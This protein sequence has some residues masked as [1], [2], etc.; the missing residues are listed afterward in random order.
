M[1][2]GD[3]RIVFFAATVLL[4]MA[5]LPGCLLLG[6]LHLGDGEAARLVAVLTF[7]GVLVTASV[8][9][10]GLMVNR[11]T[12]HRLQTEQAEQSRQLR[13]DSAMRAGQ[14]IAPLTEARPIRPPW[15]PGSSRSP[16]STTPI[17]P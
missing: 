2:T 4:V 10:I 5:V 12:E 11:Q 13:L 14:L 16:S 6:P 8:S 9:L 17:S 15:P 7:V 3:R 1:G